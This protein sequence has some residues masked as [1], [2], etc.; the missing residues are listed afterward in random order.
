MDM[1]RHRW[2]LKIGML[3]TANRFHVLGVLFSKPSKESVTFIDI[4][5]WWY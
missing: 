2:L 5:E 1:L 4:A 3:E